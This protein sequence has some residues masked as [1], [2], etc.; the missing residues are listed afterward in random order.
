MKLETLAQLTIV[1]AEF[2]VLIETKSESTMVQTMPWRKHALELAKQ[3]RAEDPGKHILNVAAEISSQWQRD[4]ERCPGTGKLIRAI[5]EW[6]EQGKLASP[7]FCLRGTLAG[8]NPVLKN[9]EPG[10]ARNEWRG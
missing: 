1:G 9:P 8:Q 4:S 2:F 6:E 10:R 5:R 7:L 3:I